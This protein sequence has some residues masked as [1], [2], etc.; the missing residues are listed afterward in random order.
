MTELK[1]ILEQALGDTI[2]IY[3]AEKR[4]AIDERIPIY[5]QA[6]EASD[7][8]ERA[9]RIR[10]AEPELLRTIRQETGELAKSINTRI[11]GAGTVSAQVQQGIE[12]KLRDIEQVIAGS[13]QTAELA[14]T[15][16][17]DEKNRL[18]I[19]DVDLA[20]TAS[21]GYLDIM[22]PFKSTDSPTET[23]TFLNMAYNHVYSAAR[24]ADPTIA[25]QRSDDGFARLRFTGGH[26]AID[27]FRE[28]LS[29]YR[30]DWFNAIKMKFRVV[31]LGDLFR[32]EEETAPEEDVQEQL[33]A[34]VT[35][36]PPVPPGAAASPVRMQ[37][38]VNL[39]RC[40]DYGLF[41]VPSVVRAN[42]PPDTKAFTM[43][44]PKA[45]GTPA[46][47]EQAHIN[48]LQG[49]TAAPTSEG[50]DAYF[51]QSTTG[52]FVRSVYEDR[53][54]AKGS[55]PKGTRLDV[56]VERLA[57]WNPQTGLG[58]EYQVTFGAMANPPP[59]A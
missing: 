4:R 36:A 3:Y 17:T 2:L 32:E 29:T 57:P 44:F 7:Q 1:E 27:K 46:T 38:T 42:F 26:V 39:R 34:T 52:E 41:E 12:A 47:F 25:I 43:H 49:A 54:W 40:A 33:V 35:Q 11:G 58:A 18:P 21:N 8:Y 59:T 9:Q 14:S 16:A 30:P 55:V 5:T 6:S 15:A 56:V 53:G 28:N 48:P 22:T 13:I 31:S 45:D 19:L 20:V 37:Y 51:G 24:A 23:N 50:K 10:K